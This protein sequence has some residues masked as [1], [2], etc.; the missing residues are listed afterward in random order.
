M[1]D[2]GKELKRWRESHGLTQEQVAT[3]MKGEHADARLSKLENGKTAKPPMED[4]VDI[5]A[6]FH[7]TPNE[8]AEL[9]GYWTPEPD[10][11]RRAVVIDI[12]R[13]LP[14][15]WFAW[16]RTYALRAWAEANLPKS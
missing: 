12:V 8:M 11:E 4:L 16:L 14:P 3:K 2:A 15:R 7:K 13:R 6:Y 5:G 1:K 10:E 9:Y